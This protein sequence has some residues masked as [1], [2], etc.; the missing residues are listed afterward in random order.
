[1]S[2]CKK[3]IEFLILAK[4]FL[5]HICELVESVN[6]SVEDLKLSVSLGAPHCLL[7]PKGPMKE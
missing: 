7:V 3:Q 2:G 4:T 1:M 5:K 6:I